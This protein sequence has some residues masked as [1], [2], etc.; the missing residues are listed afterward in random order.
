M[1]VGKKKFLMTLS[2][3]LPITHSPTVVQ[4]LPTPHSLLLTPMRSQLH[5]LIVEDV[6]DDLLLLLRELRRGGYALDYVRVDTADEMQ[7][8]LDRQTWDM[9]IADYSLPAFSA[10]AALEVLQQRQLDLPF[11]IVSGTIGEEV[12]VAAMK[13]G[14]HDYIIKGNLARLL[15]AV[16]RELRDAEERHKRQIA[17]QA[18]QDSEARFRYLSVASP[19][20]IFQTDLQG[21][22]LYTNPRWQKI[23]G[24]TLEQ[25]LGDGWLQ[26]IYP[27]DRDRVSM[28]WQRCV[29][30][31]CEFQ[32]EFRFLTAQG[33][34]HWVRSQATAIRSETGEILGYV[35]TN[36]DITDRHKSAAELHI[37]RTALES[38]VEGIAQLDSRGLYIKVNAAYAD[39]V[40]YRSTEMIGMEWQQ[41][42]HP[43]DRS[44]MERAYQQMLLQG[45]IEVETRGIRKDGSIFYKQLVM[46]TTYD[47]MQQS[48][49][50][51]CFA[52]DITER[53]QTERL[54]REQ[55][56]LLD[57]ATD[58]ISVRDLD[59]HILLWNKGAER[60]YG[61]TASEV[62]GKN[63][64][65]LLNQPNE[66]LASLAKINTELL[67]TGQWQGEFQ[68]IT[69]AG[70]NIIIEGRWTLVRDET[71]NPKSILTVSTDVTE[72]KQL[73]AQFRRAQRMESLGTLASGIA[74]DFNNIL[75]PI[76]AASQLLPFKLKHLDNRDRQLIEMMENSAK[77]GADLVKQILAFA[78][79]VEGKRVSLQVRH[80]LAEVLQ[81]VRQTFP[82]TIE[83]DRNLADAKIW[84]V[85]ADATQL[86]Q[87]FMN[88]C[89]NARDAMPDGGTLSIVV[90][91]KFLEP[92][93]TRLELDAQPGAYV[94]ISVT[95]TGTGIAPELL[96]R[97]FEPFFTTKEIGKGTGLGLS[98][99]MGIVKNH[100]GFV[101][102]NSEVGRG[103]QFQVYLPAI[104]SEILP[105]ATAP[106]LSTGHH[107]LILIVDDEPSILE[108]ARTILE[109]HNYHA[110]VASSGAEAISIYADRHQE[111]QLVLM[112]MMMPLMDG[113]TAARALQHIDPRVK[114]IISSGLISNSQVAR[115]ADIG[116]WTFL[117]KPYTAQDLLDTVQKMLIA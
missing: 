78:S 85:A 49:G 31:G 76:L 25:S 42:V 95:D 19:M 82:K 10:P 116:V 103:T 20:G 104:S 91:N 7:A 44:Q 22:C 5:V 117:A 46:V 111:I 30:E 41:T 34:I 114:T 56:A 88:L 2:N 84:N 105:V 21:K 48:I 66:P 100:G 74:H 98:T 39:L 6:E 35:G 28:E 64:I 62:I 45:K 58:A 36:E 110:I 67:Q 107:E 13:A 73:E 81:V 43:D 92:V 68:H 4:P 90:Q 27:E 59:H 3:A 12:A 113:L 63:A 115:D 102:V 93:E 9:V 47:R 24:L 69:Q 60:L 86:H 94:E 109:E 71:G 106:R 55:A 65:E 17:E 70:K 89:V 11:I 14:A 29:N 1:G 77:R 99:V 96:D 57:V 26:S 83:I 37:L 50:H 97:I 101:R 40:G 87:V 51:Y 16:E 108:V 33:E 112:D 23:A 80:P 54:I 8:A 61:W 52:K 15:P 72:K 53:K 32:L 38:A 18:L 75:T 79:G